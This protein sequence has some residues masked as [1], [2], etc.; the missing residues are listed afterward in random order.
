MGMKEVPSNLRPQVKSLLTVQDKHNVLQAEFNK[1]VLE[2]EVEYEAKF[3]PLY[4]ERA[5]IVKGSACE[6]GVSSFWLTALKNNYMVS[7]MITDTDEPALSFLNDIQYTRLE[8]NH[9]FKLEFFFNKNT[10]FTNAILT[11]TFYFTKCCDDDEKDSC[12]DSAC[13]ADSS[14]NH[15]ELYR[16]D[17]MEGTT[18][19]WLPGSNLTVKMVKRTQRHKTKNITRVVEREERVNS[20]FLFFDAPCKISSK[21]GDK[22]EATSDDED[23][24]GEV[25]DEVA[26]HLE[27][28]DVIRSKIIPDAVNWYLG[29]ADD[30]TAP[31]DDEED[32]SDYNEE[33]DDNLSDAAEDDDD[34][35]RLYS[36]RIGGARSHQSA[37]QN[38]KQQ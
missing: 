36:R 37:N 25:S 11:K 27:I 15:E 10:F 9:S 35:E 17:R 14:S 33:G 20:F 16:F 24:D 12:C 7:E 8:D 4:E 19:D 38:C 3:A 28:G 18:I 1:K 34:E 32:M 22:D 5:T 30:E 6:E 26:I 13:D 29:I 21:G 2:L 31:F 23:D